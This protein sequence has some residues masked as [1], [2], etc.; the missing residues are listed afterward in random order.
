MAALDSPCLVESFPKNAKIE[1]VFKSGSSRA[2]KSGPSR[3]GGVTA[4][5]HVQ[6][7]HGGAT[8][9]HHLPSI[10][11]PV[12]S[13]VLQV[14][15]FAFVGFHEDRLLVRVGHGCEHENGHVVLAALHVG[16]V[17]HPRER[18]S[19]HLLRDGGVWQG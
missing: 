15:T 2:M 18:R 12:I 8:H 1:V 9:T 4:S 19:L 5:R 6:R 7:T 3:G 17:H 13:P 14:P 10:V 16:I 11:Q